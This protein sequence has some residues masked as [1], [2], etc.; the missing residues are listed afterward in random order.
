[1][2]KSYPAWCS[3]RRSQL[4]ANGSVPGGNDLDHP[5]RASGVLTFRCDKRLVEIV[6]DSAIWAKIALF[7]LMALIA[8]D[9]PDPPGA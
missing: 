3:S 4:S 1:M 2:Q 5:D 6:D 7:V 8:V 9:L